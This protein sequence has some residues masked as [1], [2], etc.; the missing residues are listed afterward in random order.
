MSK[1]SKP[2][3]TRQQAATPSHK[4][5]KSETQSKIAARPISKHD[6]IL[7]LLR[8]KQGVSFG[9]MQKISGWQQHSVRGFLSGTVKKRLGLNLQSFKSKNGERR[10]AVAG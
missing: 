10:Y 1:I 5:Q 4:Q 6:Q 9:E 7:S 3:T 2:A 8:R